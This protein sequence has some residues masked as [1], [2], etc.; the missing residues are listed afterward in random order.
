MPRLPTVKLCHRRNGDVRKVNLA[1]YARDLARWSDW[2]LITTQR[3]DAP[4]D[5]VEQAIREH[6]INVHRLR[7]P[8][9][10]HKRSDH[11]RAFEARS[12]E[13]RPPAEPAPEDWRALPWFAARAAVKRRTG[14]LPRDKAH[15]EKLMSEDRDQRTDS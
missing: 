7:D 11:R 9:E 6:D 13:V 12:I 14:T 2:K 10:Q 4:P 3:G 5:I 15:A 8:A 1:E